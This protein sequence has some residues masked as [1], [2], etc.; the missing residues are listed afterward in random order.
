MQRRL[1]KG[2][3]GMS[4]QYDN[5]VRAENM[6]I[7]QFSYGSD[8]LNPTYMESNGRPIN[9]NRLIN[10]VRGEVRHF[11]TLWSQKIEMN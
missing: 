11:S 2:L 8:N 10:A 5:T 7:I 9:F 4:L 3:E 6:D 1:I